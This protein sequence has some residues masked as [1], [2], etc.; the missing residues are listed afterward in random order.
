MCVQ[1]K[2]VMMYFLKKKLIG[3][4]IAIAIAIAFTFLI[5]SGH[6]VAI[7]PVSA[8]EATPVGLWKTVDDN[9]GKTRSHVKI[10][11]HKGKLYGKI[12]KLFGEEEENPVCEDCPGKYKNKPIIGLMIINNMKKDDDEWRGGTILDPVSGKTY[13]LVLRLENGGKKLKVRGYIG[14]SL[15][16]RTQYWYRLK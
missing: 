12:T 14:V 1:Q 6:S 13:K 3:N 10:W 9:S 4:R 16:G 2:G 7:E 8:I 11:E 15:L 5:V